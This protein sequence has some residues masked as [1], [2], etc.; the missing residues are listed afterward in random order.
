MKNILKYKSKEKLNDH[1]ALV[2][3][4]YY[5]VLWSAIRAKYKKASCK[6][7]HKRTW[8]TR[9]RKEDGRR[10]QLLYREQGNLITNI[11]GHVNLAS[12]AKTF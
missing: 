12:F 4:V 9:N 2:R 11:F 7:A 10:I 8:T 6:D 1:I 5:G 3:L